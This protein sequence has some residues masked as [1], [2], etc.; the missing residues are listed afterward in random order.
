MGRIIAII[1]NKGGVGKTTLAV[2]LSHAIS[3]NKTK[4]VLVCDLDSQ[5]N[6]TSIFFKTNIHTSL[7]DLLTRDISPKDCIY[8]TDYE[9]LS[10]LPNRPDTA[11]LEPELSRRDD[12]GWFV[13]REKLREY[14]TNNFDVT[15]LDCPPNLGVFSIQAM[16]ASDFVIVPVEAG[17]RYA[18]DGLDRTVET[19]EDIAKTEGISNTGIFLKLVI[20]KADRRTAI[21]KIT[22]DQVYEVYKEKVFETIIPTNTDIQQSEL[23]GKTVIRQAPKSPGA[24]AFRMLASELLVLL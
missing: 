23:F 5:C 18:T 12:Y 20:N 19:I 4:K 24:K 6:A 3:I 11:A 2:N 22:I 21:S 15:L 17:S 10:F 13:L 14:A 16:I 9:R 1:N 7:F 8:P